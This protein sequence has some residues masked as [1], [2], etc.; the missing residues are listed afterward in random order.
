MEGHPLHLLNI[1]WVLHHISLFTATLYFEP[2]SLPHGFLYWSLCGQYLAYQP[3]S[4]IT[5]TMVS[6]KHRCDHAALLLKSLHRSP[7]PRMR[8]LSWPTWNT[9]NGTHTSPNN[10]QESGSS[11]PRGFMP[12]P[13]LPGLLFLSFPMLSLLPG[14]LCILCC[15]TILAV[16]RFLLGY[17]EEIHV[18]SSLTVFYTIVY[19]AGSLSAFHTGL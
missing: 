7:C 4:F 19:W 5:V 18:V 2:G 10:S 17:S 1:W 14:I 13:P 6:P 12:A 11:T 16:F 8:V 3:V 9:V 15:M